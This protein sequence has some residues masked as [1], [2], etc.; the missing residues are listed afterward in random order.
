M[1]VE[2]RAIVD[3]PRGDSTLRHLWC[4]WVALIV[5]GFAAYLFHGF[6]A[7]ELQHLHSAWRIGQGEL[8]YRDFFEH[9]PPLLYLLIAPLFRSFS[10]ADLTVLLLARAIALGVTLITLALLYRLLRRMV[11][12]VIACIAIGAMIALPV[13]G[14]SAMELRPDVPGLLTITGA[15]LVLLRNIQ[16]GKMAGV[17]AAFVAGVLFGTAFCFT[18]K[19]L[20]PLVGVVG[21]MGAAFLCSP[22]QQEERRRRIAALLALV[23]GAGVTVG[24]S[25]LLFAVQGAG[26]AFW[27]HAV[28]INLGWKRIAPGW[29]CMPETLLLCFPLFVFALTALLRMLEGGRALLRD[30][31]PETLPGA[32]LLAGIA[33]Q[34]VTPIPTWQSVLVFLAPWTVCLSAMQIVRLAYEPGSL[35]T[36]RLRM[37]AASA[38]VLTAMTWLNTVI[39][40]LVWSVI[41]WIVWRFWRHAESLHAR[42]RCLMAIALAPGLIFRIGFSADQV[43]KCEFADQQRMIRYLQAR[44]APGEPVLSPW[45]LLL[46][47]RPAATRHWFATLDTLHSLAGPPMEAEYIAAVE[48]GKA[49]LVVVNPR[50]MERF[51]P[52]FAHYLQ[53]HCRHLRDA[54]ATRDALRVYERHPA[55]RTPAGVLRRRT[56]SVL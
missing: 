13:F 39:G 40:A 49:R 45:P 6:D 26:G 48:G 21:W 7:D 23:A 9:H 42:L 33:G 30:A 53:T 56:P 55:R 44:I 16:P 28:A 52:G 19:A 27:Q 25:V 18:Q 32:L 47:F 1:V 14:R 24:G 34:L 38:L 31:A 37:L 11:S 43:R 5:Q 17:R 8:P 4:V 54:P 36:D 20:V 10:E 46:P 15:I 41:I 2:S 29:H 50:H 35:R 51:L 12:P 22:P 3:A